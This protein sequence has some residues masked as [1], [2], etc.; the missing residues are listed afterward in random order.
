MNE[1]SHSDTAAAIAGHARLVAFEN[2]KCLYE[3]GKPLFI[4]NEM[5]RLQ[6][7]LLP[8]AHRQ[9]LGVVVSDYFGNTHR[10]RAQENGS[11]RSILLFHVVTLSY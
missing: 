7:L 3:M 1:G 4:M 8:G 11:V 6:R 2:V 9:S 10:I 5:A